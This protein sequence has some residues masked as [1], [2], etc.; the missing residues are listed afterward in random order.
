MPEF[1]QAGDQVVWAYHPYPYTRLQKILCY[2]VKADAEFE[3]DVR[4]E[5]PYKSSPHVRGNL[6]VYQASNGEGDNQ[7]HLFDMAKKEYSQLTTDDSV[8]RHNPVFVG[9]TVV[10]ADGRDYKKYSYDIYG[11]NLETGKEFCILK[12]PGDQ[13]FFKTNDRY[14]LFSG[15]HI[16]PGEAG[17]D[18]QTMT[19]VMGLW[20]YDTQNN[21]TTAI[22]SNET[23]IGTIYC[24]SNESDPRIVWSELVK[25]DKGTFWVIKQ[26][27][28]SDTLATFISDTSALKNNQFVEMVNDTHIFY[29]S[30]DAEDSFMGLPYCYKLSSKTHYQL[31]SKEYYELTADDTYVLWTIESDI[32]G[33]GDNICGTI[34]P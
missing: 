14:V 15:S 13:S 18:S 3:I 33:E 21:T 31:D 7:V 23:Q 27:R 12:A 16:N 6:V 29:S 22:V 26:K 9:K 34:L 1:S 2:D 17:N 10:W 20:I 5:L 30:N 19:K 32:N 28:L 8:N 25:N 24:L 4:K 11:Y